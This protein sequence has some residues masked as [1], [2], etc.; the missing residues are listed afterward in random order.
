MIFLFLNLIVNVNCIAQKNRAEVSF[1][2]EPTYELVN[3][4]EKNTIIAW[5]YNIEVI[6]QN[7]GDKKSDEL[8]VNLS[9]KGDSLKQRVIIEP[10][11]TSTASFTWP[12]FS[13]KDQK[14]NVNF[15]PVDMGTPRNV[16]N[17]GKT[18]FTLIIEEADGLSSTSTPGFEIILLISSFVI[19]SILLRKKQK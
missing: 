9:I 18:S 5:T 7:T 2:G 13:D 6:L 4:L 1:L 11:N 12:F 8:F 17:S 10:G 16:Y 15:Y 14:F 19:I 3:K